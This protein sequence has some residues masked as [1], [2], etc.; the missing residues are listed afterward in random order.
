MSGKRKNIA[1]VAV[2][3][4]LVGAFSLACLLKP[5]DAVSD[6]ER[7]PLA[8]QPELSAQSVLSG[9]YMERFDA[10]AVDQFPLREQF[11]ELYAF[12]SSKVF[13]RADVEGLYLKDGAIVAK[14]YPLDGESLEH[15]S[16]VFSGVCDTYLQESAGRIFLAIVP[17]KAYFHQG[18]PSMLV[19]DYEA[20]FSRMEALNPQM[21]RIDIAPLLSADDYLATD[22]HWRQEC[23]GDVADCSASALDVSLSCDF[24]FEEATADFRGTYAGQAALPIRPERLMY[25]TSPALENVRVF[26]HQNN[27]E[28]PLYDMAKLDGR[29]P[30]EM[31]LGGPLSY[32]TIE[33]PAAPPDKELIVFRDSFG[34]ALVPYLAS[35]YGKVTVLDIRY[36]PSASLGSFVDFHGQDVLFLYSTSVLNNSETLK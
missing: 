36:L 19:M 25:A 24:T 18:D 4:V 9:A 27:R 29:D 30:Y 2:L 34:S 21:R 11:R 13:L 5:A 6:S 8:Q 14:E 16:Q 15:A 10:Y 12:M 33:N 20:L 22:P 23:I 3:A 17:D 26:D 35:G 1:V 28:M 7:R 31:Y 32:V